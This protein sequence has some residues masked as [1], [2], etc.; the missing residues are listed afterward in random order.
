MTTLFSLYGNA[1][2]S[3]AQSTLNSDKSTASGARSSAD[4]SISSLT[5][6]LQS[7]KNA[8]TNLANDEQSLALKVA[9]ANPDD[10]TVAKSSLDNA[11]ANLANAEQNYASRIITAPFDGQIGGLTAQLGQQVSSSDSLGTLITAQRVINVS[12]NE[13]DA[14]KVVANDAVQITFNALP[15]VAIAGHVNFIDPLG[16][17]SQGVVNYNVQVVLDE[18]NDLIKT[19]MTAI[20]NIATVDHPNTLMVPNSAIVTS[21][22]QKYVL[23]AQFSS[24]TMP[25]IGGFGSSTRRN[26]ASST[27]GGGY[28][29]GFGST[30]SAFSSSTFANSSTTRQRNTSS[31]GI[32]FPANMQP[33]VVKV[34]VIV[35]ISNATQTEILSG[36]T[37][38][39]FIVTRT[40][41]GAAA[42]T[43]KSAAAAATTRTIGGGAGGAVRIGGGFGGGAVGGATLG[44]AAVRL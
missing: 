39:Q 34:P 31:T 3:T 35:G 7:Y 30:S 11:N 24:S 28:G 40:I 9:P 26:F 29:S 20:A 18:Q 16:T 22:N 43:A 23:V 37:E 15:G 13:V 10:V 21:G 36:L 33:T 12:L 38:G 27:L 8:Q 1:G 2:G 14:S 19:G 44:G 6:S 5:S 32:Q 41:T 42:T 25:N 4:S 17:V